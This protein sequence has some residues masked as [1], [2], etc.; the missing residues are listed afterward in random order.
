ME[1][2]NSEKSIRNNL[3]AGSWYTI[4]NA[5]N[6]GLAFL[7][8]PVLSRIMTESDYGDFSNF[9]A[10]AAMALVVTSLD[11]ANVITRQKYEYEENFDEYMSSICLVTFISTASFFL[12]VQLFKDFFIGLF[13]FGEKYI[14]ALFLFLLFKPAID[15]FQIHQRVLIKYR[16]S[17]FVSVLFTLLTLILSISLVTWFEDGLWARTI[18]YVLPPILF[19]IVIYTFFIARGKR[20]EF[21]MVCSSL[22]LSIPLIPH[23]LSNGVLSSSDRTII[24]KYWSSEVTAKYSIGYAVGT[25]LYI[26]TMSVSQAYTPWLYEKLKRKDYEN[27]AHIHNILAYLGLAANILAILLTPEI[28]WLIGG[29]R[30][31]E[32]VSFV[33][34]VMVGVYLQFLG[35][36]YVILEQY[37]KRSGIISVISVVAAVLNVVLNLIFVP[38]YGYVSAAWT[39]LFSFGVALVMHI[40][41][42]KGTEYR[43]LINYKCIGI[44]AILSVILIWPVE[45]IM[46]NTLLRVILIVCIAGIVGYAMIKILKSLR[47]IKN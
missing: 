42:L 8:T 28:V 7:L 36:L 32:V 25:I 35:F 22:R 38:R 14:Y 27:I 47:K 20:I 13:G 9:S 12:I 24:K 43:E 34:I 45:F 3:K 2:T 5:I 30:Y 21:G 11:L 41:F 39:T 46:K 16:L 10:W 40:M 6:Q 37:L 19:G 1:I 29:D 23:N 44:L 31:K 15:Y 17:A 18:G 26:L 33:P 4:A